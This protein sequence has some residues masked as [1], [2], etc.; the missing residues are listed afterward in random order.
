MRHDKPFVLSPDPLCP[1]FIRLTFSTC[2]SQ[3]PCP[4]RRGTH[5]RTTTCRSTK[6]DD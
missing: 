3:S 4:A 5:W 1:R 2:F 6:V